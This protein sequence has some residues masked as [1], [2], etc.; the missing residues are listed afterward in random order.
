M[1]LSGFTGWKPVPPG[2]SRTPPMHRL[3]TCATIN[4]LAP[5]PSLDR[6]GLFLFIGNQLSAVSFQPRPRIGWGDLYSVPKDFSYVPLTLAPIRPATYLC[7]VFPAEPP[8]H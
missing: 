3:K 6:G 4:F 7:A 1:I 8:R 5:S 2:E